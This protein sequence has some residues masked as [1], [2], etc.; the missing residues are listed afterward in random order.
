MQRGL[1]PV[2]QRQV[3]YLP[4]IEGPFDVELVV[5]SDTVDLAVLRCSGATGLVPP[6][7]LGETPARPG[8]EVF[9]LGYPT[10]IRAL[11]V[12]TNESSIRLLPD[13]RFDNRPLHLFDSQL[14]M[15]SRHRHSIPDER[16]QRVGQPIQPPEAA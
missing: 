15:V 11:L 6:L 7:P 12:R 4:G 1:I 3:G 9:V 16:E 8:E 5:A 2:M 10:G 13:P 14:G